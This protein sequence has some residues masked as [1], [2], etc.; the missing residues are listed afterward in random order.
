MGLL[1]RILPKKIKPASKKLGFFLKSKIYTY[2]RVFFKLEKKPIFI[3]GN[4]KSGTSAIANILAKAVNQS[5]SIDLFLSGYKY[6]YLLDWK[7]NNISTEKF[8]KLNRIDFSKKIIKE[9]HLSVFYE[10]LV[11]H[12]PESK[13]VFI[14][15]NPLDNIRS[16]LDRLKING[17]QKFIENNSSKI[18][19]SWELVFRTDW[20]GG[21]ESNLIEVLSE[22][23]KIIAKIF[24][25]NKQ[26]IILVKYED[27][28]KNKVRVINELAEKLNLTVSRDVKKILNYQF[29]PRGKNRNTDP[30]KFF[31]KKNYNKIIKIC[32]SELRQLGYH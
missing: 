31:G 27:F 7:K 20:L 5:S 12:Y 17:S 14:V 24:L 22:R 8:I 16:I 6:D 10:E 28:T 15:R 23:W 29:Q 13:F 32:S 2:S 11:R 26:N 21:K 18:F 4:Q 25:E 9:P 3:L 1:Q 30:E 19:H